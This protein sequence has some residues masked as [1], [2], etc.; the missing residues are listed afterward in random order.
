MELII[1]PGMPKT[2]SSSIQ[3]TLGTRPSADYGYLSYTTGNASGLFALLFEEPID[4]YHA[5]KRSGASVTELEALRE[6][7]RGKVSEQLQAETRPRIILSAERMAMASEAAI[8][9][10]HDFFAPYV[11]CFRVVGYVRPPAAFLASTFQQHVK[12]HG[13]DRLNLDSLWPQYRLGL[14]KFDT[15]FGREAVTLRLMERDQLH[16]RDVVLDFAHVLGLELAPQDVQTT[17][18]SLSLEAVALLYAQR[19]IGAGMAHGYAEAGR[20]NG[21]LVTTLSQI[22]NRRFDLAPKLTHAVIRQHRADLTW[23]E[24]RLGQ[25]INDIAD[26]RRAGPR[27]RGEEDL[28]RIAV[29]C[30]PQLRRLAARV[31]TR[32]NAPSDLREDLRALLGALEGHAE[33]AEAL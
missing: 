22:G 20:R 30:L 32:P 33:M 3:K 6:V 25:P 16:G 24:R 14:G 28:L 10:M 19:R 21:R 23:I 9:R 12:G 2:G 7:W 15:V 4:A 1:H 31:D 8:R 17:N 13:L 18:E 26:R 5:F 11:T 27:I 29:G